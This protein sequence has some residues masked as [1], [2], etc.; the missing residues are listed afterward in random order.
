ME[1]ISLT[2]DRNRRIKEDMIQEFDYTNLPDDWDP[3]DVIERAFYG[4]E[5][6]EGEREAAVLLLAAKLLMQAGLSYEQAT[7]YIDSRNVILRIVPE[8]V[9]GA[10]VLRMTFEFKTPGEE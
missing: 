1:N 9:D 8:E 7:E 4:E 3:A 2:E 5:I 6:S 10:Q